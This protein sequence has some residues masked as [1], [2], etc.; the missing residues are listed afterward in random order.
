MNTEKEEK[1][2]EGRRGEKE[3]RRKERQAGRHNT[4]IARIRRFQIEGAS[5][6]IFL[7]LPEAQPLLI[8]M[9]N[10]ALPVVS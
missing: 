7:L 9:R 4:T 6:L 5:G 8:S 10:F 1:R 2:R 3:E